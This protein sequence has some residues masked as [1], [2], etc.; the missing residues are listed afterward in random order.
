MRQVQ[1]ELAEQQMSVF[2]GCEPVCVCVCV[3]VYLSHDALVMAGAEGGDDTH[4]L[5]VSVESVLTHAALGGV[6][7]VHRRGR[8]NVLAAPL[9]QPDLLRLTPLPTL[10]VR[11]RCRGRGREG[12]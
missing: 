1:R 6:A 4:T 5:R 11:T 9:T 2:S 7:A 12:L 10:P 3:C 8:V